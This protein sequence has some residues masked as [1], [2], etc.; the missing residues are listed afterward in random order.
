MTT[1][2]VLKRSS[3]IYIN[4]T[5]KTKDTFENSLRNPENKPDSF[6]KSVLYEIKL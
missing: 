4:V 6:D 3:R 2:M 5:Y 1:Q